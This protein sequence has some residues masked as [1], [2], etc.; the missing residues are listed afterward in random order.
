MSGTTTASLAVASIVWTTVARVLRA[1]TTGAAAG[2]PPHGQ[3]HRASWPQQVL[4]DQLVR[5]VDLGEQ[6]YAAAVP[7]DLNRAA[8]LRSRR[9]GPR[10][11]AKT[12]QIT[13]RRICLA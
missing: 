8:G 4:H 13:C 3:P 10:I 11:R 9:G 5:H 6:A 1:G 7:K 2:R 12:E